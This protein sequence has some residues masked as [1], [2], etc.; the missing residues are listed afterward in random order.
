M[1]LLDRFPRVTRFFLGRLA[2]GPILSRL[3]PVLPR[4]FM[5]ATAFEVHRVD[6]NT[7]RISIGGVDEVIFSSKFLEAFHRIIEDATG[8]EAKK[9]QAL[10]QVG[11]EGG[12]WEV[13]E[14][15]KHGKWAPR[16][17]VALI[18]SGEAAQRLHSDP[19]MAR[20]FAHTM[21]MVCRLIISEGGWG[22]VEEMDFLADP[23]RVTLLHSNEARWVGPSNKPVCH[24]CAGV[25]AGYASAIFLRDLDAVEVA[26]RATGAPKCVFELNPGQTLS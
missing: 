11:K 9:N 25:V 14:A 22:V 17:L 8:S 19:L 4:T 1:A 12:R 2:N 23:M 7:G 21:K 24:V 5:G 10:Y 18:E 3:L 16:V 13:E 26:C 20:F 6:V 15:L